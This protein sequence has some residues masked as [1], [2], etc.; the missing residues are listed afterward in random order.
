LTP[1]QALDVKDIA[2]GLKKPGVSKTG[3]QFNYL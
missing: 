1:N 3:Q 2:N